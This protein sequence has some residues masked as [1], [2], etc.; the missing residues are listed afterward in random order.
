MA[1]FYIHIPLCRKVCYYCDFHF[2]A[3]LKHKD[4]LVESLLTEIKQRS[5]DWKNHTFSTI[6]FGGGTPSVLSIEEINKLV[7]QV[8]K[9]YNI[10][11]KIEFTLEANP[12]DLSKDYLKE[13]KHYTNVNRLSVGVQSFHDKDLEFTNRRHNG[14]QAINSIKNAKEVGFENITLDLIY[15]IPGLSL[16]EWNENLDTFLQLD[17]PHLAAYHLS[18]EPKTVFGV[19]QKKNKIQEINE[20]LSIQQYNLLIDKLKAQG[21]EHYEISNFAKK[22]MY[23]K[24]NTGY[25]QGNEYI[26]IG[27]SAHSFVG[28]TRRWNIANNTKY[29]STILKE[30]SDCFEYEE[31]TN[32]DRFNDYLL[33]SLRTIWG[34]NL[35]FIKHEFGEKYFEYCQQ[36]IKK[37]T[38]ASQ[39]ELNENMFRISEK[40]WLVSDSILADLF[41]QE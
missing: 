24:H 17:I 30:F 33:T 29:C 16:S 34:A 39:L 35:N 37:Y 9:Y 22:G 5:S 31:L 32:N 6:Y 20:E 3:S 25:W 8:Y 1:G 28:N 14:G 38:D 27:P 4:I 41:Y 40:G 12:D 10:A 15:G 7:S 21:Y 23:S 13:L 36:Q 11:N 26:G 18:I 19:F 2:V